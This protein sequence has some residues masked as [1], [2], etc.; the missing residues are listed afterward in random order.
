M[1]ANF[2]S[3]P[4][5]VLRA[6][7]SLG[8]KEGVGEKDYTFALRSSHVSRRWRRVSI[9][10]PV[11]WK[12][13]HLRA[14]LTSSHNLALLQI[15]RCGTIPL[16]FVLDVQKSG[17][18][19]I[20]FITEFVVS[21]IERCATLSITVRVF[22]DLHTVLG[23]IDKATR[24]PRLQLVEIVNLDHMQN[25]GY[26]P[27]FLDGRTPSLH[28]KLNQV[29]PFWKTPSPLVCGLH[30][31]EVGR[32]YFFMTKHAYEIRPFFASLTT[33]RHLI[34]HSSILLDYDNP[35]PLIDI[36]S[37]RSLELIEST[38]MHQV[39][40]Q[41]AC[42]ATPALETLVMR[43][44]EQPFSFRLNDDGDSGW[45]EFVN[46]L[47]VDNP[48]YPVLRSLTLSRID[49][50]VIEPYFMKGF[51]KLETLTLIEVDVDPILQLLDTTTPGRS[52][53]PALFQSFLRTASLLHSSDTTQNS[54]PAEGGA[55]WPSLTSLTLDG[56]VT[57]E[58]L[59]KVMTGLR[60]CG[61]PI[62]HLALTDRTAQL[63]E[64]EGGG[65]C[66]EIGMHVQLL[67]NFPEPEGLMKRNIAKPDGDGPFEEVD[68][69]YYSD[70]SFDDA[71]PW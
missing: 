40:R 66:W 65:F 37:L 41:A 12:T 24:A 43:D 2:D 21:R 47:K 42:F 38:G 6:L 51:P 61:R 26:L 22:D 57:K 58:V 16:E 33:L 13:I 29:T 68:M 31:L 10:S 56:D 44:E 54:Q 60:S 1:P 3:L 70:E 62:T 67:A 34:L 11:L 7:I 53:I 55:L 9:E 46:S 14:P 25:T 63:L 28:L 36:P 35:N 4:D 52:F 50:T 59:S 30:T 8:Q 23:G 45:L 64:L 71:Y 32:V 15:E 19:Q 48:R 18:H 17:S 27:N 69:D 5:K 20:P 39:L 49:T